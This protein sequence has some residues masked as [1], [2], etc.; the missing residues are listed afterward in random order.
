MSE[1]KR[2]ILWVSARKAFR[3]KNAS[4]LRLVAGARAALPG[5]APHWAGPA[6]RGELQAPELFRLRPREQKKGLRLLLLHLV[7]RV[8]LPSDLAAQIINQV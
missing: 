6:F 7:H 2:R 4:A 1:A 3:E 8:S 5:R